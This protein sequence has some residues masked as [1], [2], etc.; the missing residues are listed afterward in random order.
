MDSSEKNDLIIRKFELEEKLKELNQEANK[1]ADHLRKYA[2]WL[3]SNKVFLTSNLAQEP[4]GEFFT[5][6]GDSTRIGFPKKADEL[7]AELIQT[8]KEHDDVSEKLK[9]LR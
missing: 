9:N 5:R 4:S 3:E 7:L 6:G 8:I 1:T 2:D